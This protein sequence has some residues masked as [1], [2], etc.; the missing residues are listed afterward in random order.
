MPALLRLKLLAASVGLLLTAPASAAALIVNGSGQLTG[1]TG[2]IVNGGSYDV[3]FLDG[4]CASLF[5][6]CDSSSDFTFQNAVDATTAANALFGQVFI[7][8]PSGNLDSLPTTVFGCPVG[9]SC[10]AIIP[11]ALE[12][13]SVLDVA[14]A[15]NE[16]SEALDNTSL[17]PM[18]AD[19]DSSVGH[20]GGVGVWA[21]F[22]P[23]AAVPEPST[24]AL[25]LLGFCA[26][27]ASMRSRSRR[28]LKAA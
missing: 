11:Y 26:I 6:G 27:G 4:T 24:W 13:L 18:N 8:G 7:D 12:P 3:V 25:M 5:S 23:T 17:G 19:F 22:N 16:T 14:V 15:F 1:A 2:V 20:S 9:P 21:V 10:F 28:I